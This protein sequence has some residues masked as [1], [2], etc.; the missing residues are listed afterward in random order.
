MSEVLNFGGVSSDRESGGSPEPDQILQQ[1]PHNIVPEEAPRIR[2]Y[3]H[4]LAAS[5]GHQ[6]LVLKGETKR[7]YK[8]EVK[9]IRRERNLVSQRRERQ[10][11][12]N[13]Q[14]VVDIMVSL[15]YL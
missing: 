10:K 2:H 11:K 6:K 4:A 1:A 3:I 5:G 14:T 12:S 8:T 13:K 15:V 7:V 9:E